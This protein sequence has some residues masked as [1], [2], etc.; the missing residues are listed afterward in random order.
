VTG[1][2]RGAG[3]NNVDK[4][5]E[6]QPVHIAE[7]FI[8][9]GTPIWGSTGKTTDPQWIP[10][11]E[12]AVDRCY[13]SVAL[14][15]PDGRVFSAGSGEWNPAGTP[16]NTP[17]KKDDSHTDAQFYSPPY[18]CQGGVRPAVSDAP[19]TTDYKAKISVKISNFDAVKMVSWIRIGSVTHSNNMSQSRRTLTFDPPKDG[20]LVIN[21]P[22]DNLDCPPGHYMLFV[23]DSR[24][25]P[26]VAP[27]VQLRPKQVPANKLTTRMIAAPPPPVT[28]QSLDTEMMENKNQPYVTVG[29][30]TSCPYG[31]GP[32]WG[33][34]REALLQLSNIEAV[35]PLP[36]QS[37]AVA[38]VYLKQDN[39]PDIDVWREEFAN[40]VN[41]T[42][43]MRGIEMTLSGVVTKKG[44]SGGE[45][46]VLSGNT[47][48]PDLPLAQLKAENKV[49]RDRT[50]RATWPM[51]DAEAGAFDD[52]VKAVAEGGDVE[53]KVT[54]PLIK[55]GGEYRLEVREF[56]KVKGGA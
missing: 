49:Q 15:L 56:E 6:L 24:G 47:S 33:G 8:P 44:S 13:H 10:M 5:P 46:L 55:Q 28:I 11:A 7:L 14:L 35:R 42:Y 3:F 54:G 48:R 37:N 43:L 18:L 22:E 1:G 30:T 26:A 2:T 53:V 51:T 31:L 45:H 40:F 20:K 25:V 38:Y 16:F 27:I 21:T 39:I 41:G 23:L 4:T 52:V 9:A 50:Q 36:S 34:A 32:C 29:L 19:A 17:N 12:E